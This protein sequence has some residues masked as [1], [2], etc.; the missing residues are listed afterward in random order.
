M[1]PKSKES[2]MIFG[3]I[4]IAELILLFVNFYCTV[5]YSILIYC[6]S[7]PIVS[8]YKF[9]HNE[10]LKNSNKGKKLSSSNK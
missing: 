4:V 6:L 2:K 7:G 3:G 9:L 1:F 8:G 10:D 5:F